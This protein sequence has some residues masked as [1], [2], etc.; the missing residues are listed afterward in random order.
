MLNKTMDEFNELY[1]LE[2]KPVDH[3]LSSMAGLIEDE[4]VELGNEVYFAYSVE[5]KPSPDP[6]KVIKEAIDIIYITAQQLRERGVDV[7]AALAEVHRSNM[8]KSLPI[9]SGV[10]EREYEIAEKRYPDVKVSHCNSGWL[11]KCGK[12]GKVI[13]PTTYSPAVITKDMY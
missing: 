2:R 10:C 6:L 12:T 1:G 7:D 5:P 9:D 11:L 13:K 4:I 8:S 3:D